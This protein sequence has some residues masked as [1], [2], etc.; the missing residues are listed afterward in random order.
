M[1]VERMRSSDSIEELAKELGV[2][3]RCLYKWRT[4][5]DH[6]IPGEEG[7]RPNSHESAYRQQVHQLKRMLAEKVMEVDFLKGALQKIEA[8]RQK[9]DASVR[10]SK[11]SSSVITTDSGCTQLWATE[12]QRNLNNSLIAARHSGSMGV[13]GRTVGCTQPEVGGYEIGFCR[14][15]ALGAS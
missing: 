12:H 15:P 1:A 11:S 9:N 13:L 5:L 8:R 6:L 4:K 14:R 7:P 3:R 2:T 10:T